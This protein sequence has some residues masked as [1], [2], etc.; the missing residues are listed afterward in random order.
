MPWQAESW[1]WRATVQ[2]TDQGVSILPRQMTSLRSPSAIHRADVI[3]RFL[4]VSGVIAV[5]VAL[6]PAAGGFQPRDWYPAGVGHARAAHGSRRR[7][8]AE[9]CQTAGT[10]GSRSLRSGAFTA[11]FEL[12]VLWA[13]APGAA[14]DAANLLLLG[15]LGAWVVA[16]APWTRGPPTCSSGAFASPRRWSAAG[17]LI[18]SL[19]VSDLT[20][21]LHGRALQPAAR[22]P[23]HH[24]RLRLPGRR[25]GAGDGVAAG[26]ARVGQDADAGRG[27]GAGAVRAAAAVARLGAG[28]T[29]TLLVLLAVVPFRWRLALHAAL[30]GA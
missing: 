6:M 17:T 18:G 16:L 29:V 15:V 10:C 11:L 21:S 13:D 24:R 2:Q 26:P 25:A 30:L 8:V 27:D 9:S 14:L 4:P 20:A 5:W 1:D 23:E 7:R 12:S 28:C 22:L 19:D 3:V